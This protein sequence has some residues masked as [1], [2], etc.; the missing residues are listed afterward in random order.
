MAEYSLRDAQTHLQKLITEALNGEV[1]LIH[2][3]DKQVVQLVPIQASLKPR[4]AGSARGLIQ[5]ESDFDD[6]L[7]DFAEYME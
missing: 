7:D 4:K 6:P 3:A 1:I 2:G 5:M